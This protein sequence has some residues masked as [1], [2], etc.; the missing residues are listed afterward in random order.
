MADISTEMGT[1]AVENLQEEFGENRAIFVKT[2]V[3]DYIEF[4]GEAYFTYI[5]RMYDFCFLSISDAFRRTVEVF[6]KID[7]LINNAGILNDFKWELEIDIN[8][9]SNAM[10]KIYS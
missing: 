10:K 8:L 4:E 9:V 7:I 3:T 6:G 1:I 5:L 2:D